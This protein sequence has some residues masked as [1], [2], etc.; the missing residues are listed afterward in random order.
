MK[1][2]AITVNGL[3]RYNFP[4]PDRPWKFRLMADTVTCSES[5]DTQGRAPIQAPDPGSINLTPAR[6]NKSVHPFRFDKSFTVLDPN[7][8]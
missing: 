3:A 4:G 8:I 2:D 7:W 6:S 1:A 5:F